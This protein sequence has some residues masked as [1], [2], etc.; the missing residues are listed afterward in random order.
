MSDKAVSGTGEIAASGIH[1]GG[2]AN[3][4]TAYIA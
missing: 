3:N 1:L 4:Q 2:N